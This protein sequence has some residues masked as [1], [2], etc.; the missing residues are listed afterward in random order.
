MRPPVGIRLGSAYVVLL[1]ICEGATPDERARWKLTKAQDY[2]YLNQSTCYELPGVNNA[3]EY[4]VGRLRCSYTR[5]STL[6]L[7]T[8]QSWCAATSTP[9]AVTGW[10]AAEN[11]M[12][13]AGGAALHMH[14]YLLSCVR[15]VRSWP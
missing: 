11:S 2:H 9:A 13:H 6:P 10:S 3:E 1:Q 15:S 4:K 7:V 14:L 5:R 12:L 8:V